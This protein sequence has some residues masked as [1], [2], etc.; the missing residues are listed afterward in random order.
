MTWTNHGRRLAG[1]L[2]GS[3]ALLLAAAGCLG[4]LRREMPLKQSYLLEARR[5]ADAQPP[6]APAV[7]EWLRIQPFR[8][9]AG[10]EGKGLPYRLDDLRG[11]RES[12]HEFASPP[13]ALLTQQA[14][15]WL[16]AARLFAGV[17]A[18]GGATAAAY[19]LEG[20]LHEI[21]A[22]LRGDEPT[23]VLELQFTLV[24]ERSPSFAVRR[25][26]RYRETLPLPDATPATVV[27]GLDQALARI[28]ARLEADLRQE[29][30]TPPAPAAPAPAP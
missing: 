17:V 26:A 24:D 20:V 1:F 3:A 4:G 15:D 8:A 2:T 27:R 14:R 22:D 28:L 10:Q 13:A 19:S 6:A 11:R 7:P 29:L 18:P 9:T 25:Q 30:A 5:P 23:A 16:G 12:L 21:G